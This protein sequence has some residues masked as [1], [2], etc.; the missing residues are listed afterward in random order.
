MIFAAR[1][2]TKR[3]PDPRDA[4]GHVGFGPK[5]LCGFGQASLGNFCDEVIA[6]VAELHPGKIV[7]RDGLTDEGTPGEYRMGTYATRAISTRSTI[8]RKRRNDPA[9]GGDVGY[10]GML[11]MVAPPVV[12]P[13]AKRHRN[14]VDATMLGRRQGSS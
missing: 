13:C 12:I 11:R 6:W 10:P 4:H 1:R 2:A 8:V 14:R 7:I 9:Y 3:S 5:I